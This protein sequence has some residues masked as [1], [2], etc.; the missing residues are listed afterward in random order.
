M[1]YNKEINS[2]DL[3]VDKDN[4]NG[5]NINGKHQEVQKKPVDMNPKPF[6]RLW[7]S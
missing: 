4:D 7:L 1:S 5:S 2:I 3:E 6:F